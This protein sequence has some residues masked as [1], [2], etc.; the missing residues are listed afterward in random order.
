MWDADE[1][2][3]RTGKPV[4]TGWRG[5]E[6]ARVTTAE[7]VAYYTTRHLPPDWWPIISAGEVRA[8]S[9][10]HSGLSRWNDD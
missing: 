3:A 6:D 9:S 2:E 1:A 4:E 7:A 5:Y 8:L 10:C